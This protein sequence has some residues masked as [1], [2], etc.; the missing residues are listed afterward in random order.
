MYRVERGTTERRG[1]PAV[2][3]FSARDQLDAARRNLGQE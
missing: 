2:L 3:T 1:R